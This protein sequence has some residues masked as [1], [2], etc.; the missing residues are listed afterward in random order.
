LLSRSYQ[1]GPALIGA[2]FGTGTNGAYID[3]TRSIKKLGEESI[4]EAEVGG[5]TA[6]KYMVV[7]TE[8]GAMDNQVSRM[9][10]LRTNAEI[11]LTRS[12]LSYLF[13]SL[14]TSSTENPSIHANRLSRNWF[15]ECV[16]YLIP[17]RGLS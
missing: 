16:S 10:D 6:G 2:I 13:P 1:N 11:L 14:T 4:K 7:N 8:W 5:D 9:R 3:R 12:E 15:L 17:L